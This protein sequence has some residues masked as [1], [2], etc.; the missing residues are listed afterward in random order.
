M[1]AVAVS[2]GKDSTATLLY[3]T[4]IYGRDSVVA[5]FNDTG[6]ESE[7]TY[8]YLKYLEK[9]VGI[10]IQRLRTSD[11]DLPSLILRKKRFPSPNARFCTYVFKIRPLAEFV[12][13]TPRITEVW[14]G[15]RR[16]ES[17]Q[18]ARRYANVP[19]EGYLYHVWLANRGGGVSRAVREEIEKR[20]VRLRFP[21]I[22]W[23]TQDVFR[24]IRRHGLEFN[25]LYDLGFRRVGCY[26][27]LLSG[28]QDWLL[29]WRTEE[30]RKNI[31]RLLEIQRALH[32]RGYRT[33]LKDGTTIEERIGILE[34][35]ASQRTL[36]PDD[37]CELCRG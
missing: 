31:L 18:R 7:I 27:C 6:W 23:S 28:Y 36:W 14:L 10:K 3:A 13:K 15:I 37:R 17:R 25:P 4:E 11:I 19:S 35:R 2:G 24:Y 20:E 22:D 8:R 30:G 21:L 34:S 32:A 9:A 29:C 26:P 33:V 16:S 5:V 12:A 1:I